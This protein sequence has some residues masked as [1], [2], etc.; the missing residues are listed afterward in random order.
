MGCTSNAAGGGI[1][2]RA[3]NRLSTAQQI[4]TLRATQKEVSTLKAQETKA[5][6]QLRSAQYSIFKSN[7]QTV[8]QAKRKYEKAYKKRR[9]AQIKLDR[10]ANAYSGQ[11]SLF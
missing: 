7:K 6:N 5:Y 11:T 2:T 1:S 9:D 10:Y 3:F 8:K 4:K